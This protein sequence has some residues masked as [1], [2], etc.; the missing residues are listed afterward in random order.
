MSGKKFSI[1]YFF[2]FADAARFCLNGSL[3]AWAMIDLGLL[4]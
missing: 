1:V 3:V 4:L 2:E